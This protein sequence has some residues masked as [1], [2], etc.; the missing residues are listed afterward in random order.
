M[1]QK[2]TIW[3][4]IWDTACIL[5]GAIF[6]T[7][8]VLALVFL[9][10]KLE[11]DVPGSREMWIG[12]IGA[13]LGGAYTLLGVQI[14]IRKQES[15]DI[16]RKRLEKMPIL[17]FKTSTSCLE[18]FDGQGIFTLSGDEFFTT[19]F[20]ENELDNYPVIEIALAY[21]NPAFDVH[22]DSCITTEHKDVPKQTECYFP[23]EYRLV[24]DEKIQ[25]MFWIKSDKK[26]PHYSAQGILR[27]AYSDVFGNPYY[28]DVSFSYNEQSFD[29]NDMLTLDRVMSPVLANK[30][31]PTLLVRMRE[32]YSYLRDKK[33][34]E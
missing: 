23:Q 10:E 1:K 25:N 28:Q 27:V 26:Y 19:G 31:A 33:R 6:V 13:I 8:G 2:N 15:E 21:D 3:Q 4:R 14:T 16:D 34:E 11:I 5:T 30:K 18:N 24:N 12:L 29:S 20:P 32:E 7:L 9:F 17:K 22:I